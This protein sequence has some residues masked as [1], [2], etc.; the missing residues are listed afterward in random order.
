MRFPDRR[1]CLVLGGLLLLLL[2]GACQGGKGAPVFGTREQAPARTIAGER[3]ELE[4]YGGSWLPV[5]EVDAADRLTQDLLWS[6][7][8]RAG[9]PATSTSYG[10]RQQLDVPAL[11]APQAR[12]VLAATPGAGRRFRVLRR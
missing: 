4:R 5:A 3:V 6:A 8:A 9:I 7:L 10:A 12:R 1:P 2:A 11:H